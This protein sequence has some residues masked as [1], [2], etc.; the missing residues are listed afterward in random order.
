VKVRWLVAIIILPGIA[1]GRSAKTAPSADLAPGGRDGARAPALTRVAPAAVTAAPPITATGIGGAGGAPSGAENYV[2]LCAPCHGADGQGYIADHAPSLVNS[3]FLES[4]SDKFLKASIAFGRPG[5]SMSA[6]GKLFGGP[7]DDPAIDD[8]VGFLRRRGADAAAGGGAPSRPVPRAT[9]APRGNAERGGEIY[10]RVC[11]SCHGDAQ[12]RVEAVHLA[13]GSFLREASDAFIT[14]A[15]VRGRPGTKMVAF[16]DT[17]T[18]GQIA[19]VVA[20]VRAFE[21]A[22][23]VVDM[24]PPPTG[25]EPLVLN[26]RGKDPAF[27]VRDQRF[28]GVDQ[29]AKALAEHR[30]LIIVDARPP[31]EWMRVHV[32][33]A[34]SIPYHD[35]RRLDEI[36]EAVWVVA[37]CACPHHL[38]GIVVDAL[39]Q[40]GHKRALILDEGI[41]VWHR[42]GFPVTAARGV[43]PPV[44]EAAPSPVLRAPTAAP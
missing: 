28:V 19:D 38:S 43:K 26:P 33:G 5:T 30:R 3:T 22:E 6:Y 16:A 7:L 31:S 25:H 11:K 36:P 2:R 4:A 27:T 24:L 17:L 12:Q 40:R 8:L 13:N 41:N 42:Q 39:I 32:A 23:G 10:A 1:C 37:Y 9:A 29:V 35:L 18:A 15:I 20:Y 21:H 14:H 34:V 44:A